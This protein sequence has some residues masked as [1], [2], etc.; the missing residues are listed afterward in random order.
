MHLVTVT[1][2]GAGHLQVILPAQTPTTEAATTVPEKGPSPIAPEKKELLWGAGAFIV[3]AILVRFFLFPRLKK[4]MDARHELIRSELEDA[5][6]IRA[7]AEAELADVQRRA[8][9]GAG[10]GQ[11]PHRRR[12]PD[13]WRASARPGWPR[14]TPS[15]A[16][17]RSAAAAEAEA[18]K[19][20]AREQVIAAGAQ[21]AAVAS[22]ARARPIRG[23]GGGPC[24]GRGRDERGG[25]LMPMS[26]TL[27]AIGLLAE[28]DQTRT[29][30]WIFPEGPEIIWGTLSFLD[31][32]LPAVEVRLAPGQADDERPHGPHP[33]A[34]RRGRRRRRPGP[35]RRRRR[36]GPPRATSTPSASG[37]SPTP[38]SRPPAC[39]SDGRARARAGGGRAE[40]KA[41]SEIESVQGRL[42]SEV[43]AE[44]A[45]LA[46]RAT[47]RW[48]ASR[49]TTQLQQ[50]LVEDFIARVG[51]AS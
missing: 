24:R 4:G 2:S 36:S 43:Q 30:S 17:R 26:A 5:E 10:R 3:L 46:A 20:A 45:E 41:E 16:A 49:S 48:W 47:E 44:V 38:T 1:V 13:A 31:R 29:S 21:V 51:A 12:P 42:Q 22:R 19:A 50:Q 35:R 18:A 8:G 40:A 33:G 25:Q 11:R 7:E 39:V 23:S 37:C 34:A 15:V 28:E 9:A 27:G 14:S 32:R 6:R